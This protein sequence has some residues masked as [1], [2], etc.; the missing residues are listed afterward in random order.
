MIISDEQLEQMQIIQ[1]T[2][3][4]SNCQKTSVHSDR[5]NARPI[6]PRNGRDVYLCTPDD[7]GPDP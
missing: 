1:F 6:Q 3:V 2:N 5:S 7:F 4:D